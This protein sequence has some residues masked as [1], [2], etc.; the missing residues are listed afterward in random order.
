MR[1]TLPHSSLNGASSNGPNAMASTY[2]DMTSGPSK[3]GPMFGSADITSRDGG[4]R[5]WSTDLSRLMPRLTIFENSTT[6]LGYGKS[7]PKSTMTVCRASTWLELF[8]F[9]EGPAGTPA[10]VI[11]GGAH[12]FYRASDMIVQLGMMPT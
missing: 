12:L 4:T 6:F 5:S 11:F 10:L 7:S 2:V 9:A 3:L 8:S 1:T